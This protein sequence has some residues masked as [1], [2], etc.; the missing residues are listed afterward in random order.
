MLAASGMSAWMQCEEGMKRQTM[1]RFYSH[2]PF[3]FREEEG[4]FS[5]HT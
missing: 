4:S 3:V 1:D 5:S 2:L